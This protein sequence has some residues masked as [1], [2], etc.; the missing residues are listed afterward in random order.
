MRF[1]FLA[2]PTLAERYVIADAETGEPVEHIAW[3]DTD[4][5]TYATVKQRPRTFRDRP[6]TSLDVTRDGAPVLIT[7]TRPVDVIDKTVSPFK[8][9]LLALLDDPDVAAKVREILAGSP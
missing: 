4:A 8:A 9:E 5:G 3:V 2:D 7:E 6:G 1:D